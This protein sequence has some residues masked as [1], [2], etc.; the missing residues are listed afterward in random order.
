LSELER[1][2]FKQFIVI[3]R[4]RP[5]D[6]ICE[7]TW[8]R[9]QPKR[10]RKRREIGMAQPEKQRPEGQKNSQAPPN[11]HAE[12]RADKKNSA[13]QDADDADS[14]ENERNHVRI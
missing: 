5:E 2:S 6:E 12:S 8:Q 9:D 13:N 4:P 10:F 1:S 11:A 7:K 14:E 3:G